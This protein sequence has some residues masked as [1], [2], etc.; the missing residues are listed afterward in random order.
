MVIKKNSSY[1]HCYT[2]SLWSTKYY[3]YLEITVKKI[4]LAT[5]CQ[6]LGKVRL[7]IPTIILI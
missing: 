5:A 7:G 3:A 1:R 2:Y 4:N 6:S